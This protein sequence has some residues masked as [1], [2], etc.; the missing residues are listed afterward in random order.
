M[1]RLEKKGKILSNDIR[2]CSLQFKIVDSRQIFLTIIGD[3]N[4]DATST[5]DEF[6]TNPNA[7]NILL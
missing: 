2:S 5:T 7:A 3:T 4:I 1:Q 6:S